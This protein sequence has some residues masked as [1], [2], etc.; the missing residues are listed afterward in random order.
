MARARRSLDITGE[1]REQLDAIAASRSLPAALVRR[2]KIVLLTE[3]G[4]SDRERM[5]DA[6]AIESTYQLTT[7]EE[8]ATPELGS[9]GTLAR[10]IAPE[11]RMVAVTFSTACADEFPSV[12]YLAPGHPLL[13]QLVATLLVESDTAERLSKRIESREDSDVPLICG[14]GR[15]D[16]LGILRSAGDIAEERSIEVLCGWRDALVNNRERS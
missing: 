8:I 9:E 11:E 1:E 7:G 10:A 4:L 16:T 6:L 2:A 13:D 15:S 12:Q 3:D 14:W 5:A